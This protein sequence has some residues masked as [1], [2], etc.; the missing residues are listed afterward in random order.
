M[1]QLRFLSEEDHS[2]IFG[3]IEV[4][5][6]LHEGIDCIHILYNS[7]SWLQVNSINQKYCSILFTIWL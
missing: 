3:N 4:I 5:L 7:T 2:K 6:S 1:L